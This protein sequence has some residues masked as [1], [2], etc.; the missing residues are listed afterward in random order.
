MT[1]SV[2]IPF[3]LTVIIVTAL[4]LM[5]ASCPADDSSIEDCSRRNKPQYHV[6]DGEW[7]CKDREKR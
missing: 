3:V 1:A 7:T 6:Q 4:S 5:Q 2:R